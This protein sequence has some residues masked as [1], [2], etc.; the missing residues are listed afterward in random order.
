MLNRIKTFLTKPLT[1]N[2]NIH[3]KYSWNILSIFGWIEFVYF[4]YGSIFFKGTAAGMTSFIFVLFFYPITFI[5]FLITLLTE[6]LAKLSIKNENVIENK[7]Y[8]VLRYIGLII[9][10]Y[11]IIAL[12]ICVILY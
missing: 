1:I 5:I 2:I 6:N 11:H 7:Q 10:F 8:K 12:L 4:I 3:N 9:W